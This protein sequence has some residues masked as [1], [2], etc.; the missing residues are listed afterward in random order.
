LSDDFAL[1]YPIK[2]VAACI[3]IAAALMYDCATGSRVGTERAL[4]MTLIMLGAILFDRQAFTM[5]NLGFSV[6]AVVV[7]EPEA[8]VGASF[9]LSFAAVAALIAVQEARHRRLADAARADKPDVPRRPQETSLFIRA[10][11]ALAGVRQ[12]LVSTLCATAATASFMAANFHD[13][14]PYV[15]I[16][17]PLTLAII[18]FLRCRGP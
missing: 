7:L 13:L 11:H 16:G 5:R 17:N 8:L 14:S 12:L 18:E 2:K 4:F 3:A 6:L 1:R 9:Q 15:V 10:G